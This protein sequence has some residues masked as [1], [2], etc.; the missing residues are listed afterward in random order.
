M[1]K[2]IRNIF[3][4]ALAM[5]AFSSCHDGFLEED[6]YSQITI[7]NS[8]KTAEDAV[9]AANA[10]YSLIATDDYY[11]DAY[12]L[13]SDVPSDMLLTEW[14]KPLDSYNG[15]AN[16][17][18][19]VKRFWNMAWKVNAQINLS[20]DKVPAINMDGELKERVLGELKFLRALN[21]FNLVRLFGSIP[22]ITAPTTDI[23]EMFV[24]QVPSE[25]IY[26][27][28]V[29]DLQFAE[30]ALPDEYSGNDIGRATKW[31]ATSLLARVYLTRAGYHADPATSELIKGDDQY[32]RL[33]AD[34]CLEVINSGKYRL[35]E[36]FEDNF[37]NTKENTVEDIF[38]IQYL[39]GAGGYNGG[40]G[41][42]K[43]PRFVPKGSGLAL[44]EW[45]AYAVEQDFYDRFPDDSRKKATFLTEYLDKNDALITIPSPT[46]PY[47][48]AKKYLSDIYEGSTK[49]FKAVDGKDY[50]DN[51]PVIRF[52]DVLLMYSEAL[53]ELN[54]PD[55][56]ADEVQNTLYGINLVRNRAGA[57]LYKTTDF[58]GDAD[59][60][61]SKILDE[62]CWELCYEGHGWFDYVRQGV[63]LEKMLITGRANAI[64]QHNYLMPIPFD[65]IQTNKNLIQNNGY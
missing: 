47:P 15:L 6:C 5:S 51:Y 42:S 45:K 11:D 23:R 26:N 63:L 10:V 31:A 16:T 19:D 28:I 62:R 20:L 58:D 24:K 61:R 30:T 56:H 7:N 8:F 22:K 37:D 35:F 46:L 59:L 29:E 2:I 64:D 57:P 39:D 27:L 14:K 13:L 54:G 53:N 3:V 25:E 33:C 49:S 41:S 4:L 55:Y 18:K 48:F 38:S 36:N 50:G 65:A 32:Y 43:T 52:A 1:K 12:I 34:K 60:F 21:Y 17:D 40:V 44:V 9:M